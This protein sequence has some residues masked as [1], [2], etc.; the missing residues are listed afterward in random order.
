MGNAPGT[1]LL[2]E[3]DEVVRDSAAEV[4]REEGYIV[5]TASN[6]KEALDILTAGCQPKAMLL[7]LMMPV[8]SGWQLLML[9]DKSPTIAPGLRVVV[10]TAASPGTFSNLPLPIA[11]TLRKPFPLHEL[12]D[13]L[14]RL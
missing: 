8:M 9:L 13:V 12:L 6:G 5:V 11:A 3:D 7:D 14:D 2:V 10:M 1:V 4:L